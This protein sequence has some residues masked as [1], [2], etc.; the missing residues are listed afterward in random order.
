MALIPLVGKRAAGR[1][2]IVDDDVAEELSKFRWHLDQNGDVCRFVS[3]YAGGR[4]RKHKIFM[5]QEVLRM[6]GVYPFCKEGEY[7]GKN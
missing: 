5:D 4:K 7:C 1:S 3:Y 6:A 2:T